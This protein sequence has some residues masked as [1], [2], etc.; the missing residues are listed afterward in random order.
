[1]FN[2]KARQRG[3]ERS[4]YLQDMVQVKLFNTNITHMNWIRNRNLKNMIMTEYLVFFWSS[5][6]MECTCILFTFENGVPL[7]RQGASVVWHYSFLLMNSF[8]KTESAVFSC[9]LCFLGVFPFINLIGT[10]LKYCLYKKYMNDKNKNAN[11]LTCFV[12]VK[13]FANVDILRP[14]TWL[15]RALWP[16]RSV[17]LFCSR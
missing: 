17:L 15:N 14:F 7:M 1:M 5:A 4:L 8:N 2:G 6:I 12:N 11:R 3:L 9:R 13:W 16:C 10:P